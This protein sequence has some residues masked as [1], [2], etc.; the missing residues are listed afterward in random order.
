MPIEQDRLIAYDRLGHEQRMSALA[1]VA[2]RAR[3]DAPQLM[4]L[5]DLRSLTLAVSPGTGESENP[6]THRPV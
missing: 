5:G 1:P 6:L 4:L 2:K 3:Y